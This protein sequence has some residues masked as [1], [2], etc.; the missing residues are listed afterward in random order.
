VATLWRIA[1]DT[2][3]YLADDMTGGGAK[4]SGGRWNRPGTPMLYTSGSIAL[5]ML[6]TF[7]H[8]NAAKLPLNRFL[9]RIDVPDP[10]WAAADRSL[11]GNLPVGWNAIPDSKTS[12][13]IGEDWVADG[14]SALL[15]V[16]SV[17]VEEEANVLIN[18]LHRDAAS[19]TATKVRPCYY[20]SLVRS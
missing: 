1:P 19:I 12:H 20:H 11:W 4:T 5:S 3:E 16:P 15:M 17:I 2:K 7:A 10:V 13:D 9:V 8:H 14:K 18:P 6:E